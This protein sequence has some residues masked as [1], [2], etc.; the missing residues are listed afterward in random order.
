MLA[1]RNC[2]VFVLLPLLSAAQQAQPPQADSWRFKIQSANVVVDVIV[3]DRK[4]NVVAGLSASDF[5]VFENGL[6]QKILSFEA[7]S[8]N[9]PGDAPADSPGVLVHSGALGL[10][11]MRLITMVLD[12]ADMRGASLKTSIDAALQFVDKAIGLED[13]VAVYAI[14]YDV[15]LVV[16]FSRD[17]Q[18]VNEGLRSLLR[19]SQEIRTARSHESTVAEINGLSDQ[20]QSLSSGTGPANRAL[21]AM[22]QV[23]RAT[24]Q[25]ALGMQANMQTLILFRALRA[26]AQASGNLPGRKNVV[27]FSEGL[28]NTTETDAGIASVVDAANRANVAFYVIDPSG[29][30]GES[31]IAGSYN[32]VSR[33][34]SQVSRD[35]ANVRRGPSVSGGESKFD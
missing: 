21:A 11:S 4:G 29:L 15:R 7:P 8:S 30:D 16:P 13:Y 14:G 3:T 12:I 19:G 34:P 23:E 6:P 31:S 27:L 18:K 17:K 10:R 26:I 28:P 2:A 24:L 1:L 32:S 35:K 5:Q 25:T 9:I 33:D 22:A 20:I